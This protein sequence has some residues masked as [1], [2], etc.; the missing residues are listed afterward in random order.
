MG[1]FSSEG[2]SLVWY[3]LH[4][5]WVSAGKIY[6]IH[7]HSIFFF[8][9]LPLVIPLVSWIIRLV[10]NERHKVQSLLFETSRTWKRILQVTILKVVWS[11]YYK[12]A[13]TLI[14]HSRLQTQTLISSLKRKSVSSVITHKIETA[15]I[16]DFLVQK[17]VQNWSSTR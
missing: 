14:K 6:L 3:Y 12:K 1:Y 15:P 10:F 5:K 17:I 9:S 8:Y 16:V 2:S 7:R 4:K 11:I 13:I